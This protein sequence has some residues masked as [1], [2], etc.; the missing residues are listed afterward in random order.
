MK[1]NYGKKDWNMKR[2]KRGGDRWRR[3]REDCLKRKRERRKEF[4]KKM[5]C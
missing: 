2:Q 1:R 3:R 5:N 4:K